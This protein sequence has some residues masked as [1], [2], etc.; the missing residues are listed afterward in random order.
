MLSWAAFTFSS[1]F[2]AKIFLS[3]SQHFFNDVLL[4]T[5]SQM[6][7]AAMFMFVT[8]REVKVTESLD[9]TTLFLG[10]CHAYG[11]LMTNASLGL[12][13]ASLTHMIKMSEPLVTSTLMM[14]MGKISFRC[15]LLLLILAIF[16]TAMGSEDTSTTKASMTGG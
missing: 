3:D 2:Y 12:S 7:L 13:S 1:H 6:L 5:S 14:I 8:R 15:S 4:L 11:S 9:W 16:L 10:A